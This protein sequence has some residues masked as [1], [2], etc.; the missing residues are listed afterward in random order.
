[1]RPQVFRT[2]G[3]CAVLVSVCGFAAS[4]AAQVADTDYKALYAAAEYDKAL[5]VASSLDNADAQQYK[6]LCLLALGR[7]ADANA[8]IEELVTSSPTFVPSSEDTPPRFVELVTKVRQKLLPVIARRLFAEGRAS[9][10]EKQ[11]EEAVKRF[12]LVLT[13]LSDSAFADAEAKQDLL[14]LAQGYMDL[15][16]ATPPPVKFTPAPEPV[17]KAEAPPPVAVPPTVTQ[18][19]ALLQTVPPMPP[20]I[21]A[22]VSAKMVL[23][24]LIDET[25][26]VTDA[27]VKESV[28][29]RYDRMVVQAARDWR[30][31]AATRN[32]VPIP[33]EQTVTI[34][35][36]R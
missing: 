7:Q 3:A 8:T 36:K 14:T 2:I 10:T 13:L 35:P 12:S 24:V 18:P 11:P 26:R 1:M 19:T 22:R 31:T 23:V 32:G 27:I 33:S 28:H 15:A 21:A 5:E 30:Y 4:T 20:D 34:Q 6:A 9:Y 29:P 16:K 25:G 17:V